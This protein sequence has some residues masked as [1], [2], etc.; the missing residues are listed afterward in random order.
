MVSATTFADTVTDRLDA[1]DKRLGLVEQKMDKLLQLMISQTKARASAQP[2]STSVPSVKAAA[3]PVVATNYKPGLLL[4][5]Y[6]INRP[7]DKKYPQ[8]HRGE[9]DFSVGRVLQKGDAKFS[10]GEFLKRKDLASMGSISTRKLVAQQ[11]TGALQ[12]KE[13]GLH[14][15]ALELKRDGDNAYECMQ[16]LHFDGQ[17]LV[18]IKSDQKTDYKIENKQLQL[19]PGMYDLSLWQV[20]DHDGYQND[21]SS[22]QQHNHKKTSA[23]IKLKGP[24]DWEASVVAANRL[25]HI[26]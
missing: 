7:E 8:A 20:C 4:D 5:V 26:Q 13:A 24:K 2:V 1:Q 25:F 22:Y 17:E 11:Y 15:L 14:V 6:Q 19:E 12:V 9:A 10:F 21:T 23:V 3:K 18:A 16:T